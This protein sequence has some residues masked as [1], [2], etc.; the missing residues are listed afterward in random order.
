MSLELEC[1]RKL[2]LTHPLLVKNYTIHRGSILIR[3]TILQSYENCENPGMFWKKR[4]SPSM[5]ENQIKK[6]L[7]KLGIHKLIGSMR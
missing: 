2:F 4:N 1:Q 7:N 6:Y 5:E 3:L